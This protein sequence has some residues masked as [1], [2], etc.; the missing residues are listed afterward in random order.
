MTGRDGS[1]AHDPSAG[2]ERESK[3]SVVVTSREEFIIDQLRVQSAQ[4]GSSVLI[5]SGSLVARY[6]CN[7]SAIAVIVGYRKR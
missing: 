1:A 2:A 6:K 5:S 4:F 7:V 3:Y